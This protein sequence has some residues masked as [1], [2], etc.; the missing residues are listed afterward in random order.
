VIVNGDPLRET[1]RAAR[2]L[3]NRAHALVGGPLAM[4]RSPV[5][6]PLAQG[7]PCHG[8]ECCSSARRT[9][10]RGRCPA[11]VTWRRA[12]FHMNIGASLQSHRA[13]VSCVQWCLSVNLIFGQIECASSEATARRRSGGQLVRRASPNSRGG[14]VQRPQT[15]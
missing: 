7:R 5:C 8:H 1:A 9:V 14:I 10:P 13:V 12:R 11:C 3:G 15:S 6:A 2:K 4:T